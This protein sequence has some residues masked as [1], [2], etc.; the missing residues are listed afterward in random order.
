MGITNKAV[1][2][3]KEADAWINFSIPLT[4]SKT[5]KTVKRKL[6]GIPLNESDKLQAK[7]INATKELSVEEFK[8]VFLAWFDKAQ[9]EISLNITSKEDSSDEDWDIG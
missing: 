2:E 8:E 4:N 7:L 5:G 3:R 6:G 9:A 1:V